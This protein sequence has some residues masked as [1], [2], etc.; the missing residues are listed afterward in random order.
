MPTTRCWVWTPCWWPP[1]TPPPWRRCCDSPKRWASWR[2]SLATRRWRCAISA[3]ATRRPR[4][5]RH[6]SSMQRPTTTACSTPT[7]GPIVPRCRPRSRVCEP[8]R[9]LLLPC[10]YARNS[11][12]VEV[13]MSARLPL[14]LLLS[15]SVS[16][17]A[18]GSGGGSAP[19]H[20]AMDGMDATPDGTDAEDMVDPDLVGDI[21]GDQQLE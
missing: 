21:A 15:V 16:F 3:I 18:C 14:V 17:A 7:A 12:R 8:R 11:P 4:R 20:D 9:C 2:G 5:T 13:T 10:R 6:C 19:D 1:W